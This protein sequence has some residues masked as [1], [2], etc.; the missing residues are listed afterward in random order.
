MGAIESPTPLSLT[1]E[2]YFQMH[3][4][5]VFAPDARVELIDGVIYE[6]PP[7][8]S[9]H[10]SITMRL[11]EFF[12]RRLAGQITLSPQG[13]LV[14]PPRSVPQPDIQL[15]L[16]RDDFYEARNPI[17]ADTL[18]VVEVSDSSLRFDRRIKRPIY[19]R[20]GIAEMWI[21]DVRGRRVEVA[22]EPDGAEY[23]QIRL[24]E[25]GGS[26]C[27]QAMPEFEV[28]WADVF[29]SEAAATPER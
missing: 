20:E 17:A 11:N 6:M 13:A 4:A 14:L 21:V 27:L 28:T 23:R 19:A 25:R 2:Q 22:T 12:L 7:L 10:H 1:V 24:L 9:P 15:L 3:E 16:R 8:G 26:V 29:G 5:G 18:L